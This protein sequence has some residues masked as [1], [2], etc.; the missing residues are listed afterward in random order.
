MKAY[1]YIRFSTP[2]QRHGFSFDRQSEESL[3]LCQRHGWT[4]DN[5]VRLH[6]LGRSG[7]HG[8][9]IVLKAFI[10]AIK[11]GDVSTPSVLIVERLDRLSREEIDDALTLWKSI[12]RH[13]VLIATAKPERIYDKNSLNKFTD[14]MEALFHF[15]IAHEESLNKSNKAKDNW[16]RKRK[17]SVESGKP[18]TGK[19]PAWLTPDFQIIEDKAKVVR[20]IYR[21][22]IDGHGARSIQRHLNEN[23]ITNIAH[24]YTKI[25]KT[26]WNLR[27]VEAIL[28]DKHTFGEHQI[29]SGDIRHRVPQ[30]S[31]IKGYFPAVITEKTFYQAQ[32]A[33]K[34][35]ATQRG[36]QGY[37]VANI[38]QGIL[39]D[40]QGENYTLQNSSVQDKK[41]GVMRRLAVNG[42]SVPACLF[43]QVFLRCLSEIDAP[44]TDK[45]EDPIPALQAKLNALETDI[46]SMKETLRKKRSISLMEVLADLD[47]ERELVEVQIEQAKSVSLVDHKSVV[48]VVDKLAKATDKE[49][50]RL[51]L[52]GQ[53]R[54]LIDHIELNISDIK[55]NRLHKSWGVYVA[56]HDR[57]RT[58]VIV[59]T[60][61]GNVISIEA[62]KKPQ[63]LTESQRKGT[64]YEMAP[65]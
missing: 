51:K 14:L 4:L 49:A 45:S 31:P 16:S 7:F 8:H 50:I 5:T 58:T 37:D 9:Q 13:G 11:N 38:F 21:M 56:F 34:S 65:V 36:P 6:D 40:R 63:R 2:E 48:R 15:Y 47:Q 44:M 55:G 35:R 59:V 1:S 60:W 23:N 27:Y 64:K 25:S 12:L 53:L 33:R 42:Q 52:K 19:R 39:R 26:K 28:Q 30:G 43:E 3:A 41:K 18:I 24:G 54:Q 20:L 10:E 22:A 57:R 29:F 17:N 46:A 62:A 61:K 32:A